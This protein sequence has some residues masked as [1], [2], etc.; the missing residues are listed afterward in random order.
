MDMMYVCLRGKTFPEMSAGKL[1]LNP[2]PNVPW[3]DI[4]VDFIMGLP[5][6]QGYDTILVICK[7]SQNKSILF[8][9]QKR[10]TL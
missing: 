6:A 5:E 1:M 10:Q 2:I 8:L 9:L 7:N 4:S 3:V